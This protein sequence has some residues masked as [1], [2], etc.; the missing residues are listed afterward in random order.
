MR[1]AIRHRSSRP[2]FLYW[3]LV[4]FAALLI[5][6]APIVLAQSSPNAASADQSEIPANNGTNAAAQDQLEQAADFQAPGSLWH[7]GGFV[8]LGLLY[9][10]NDPENHLFR[11]SGTTFRVNELDLNMAAI[12]LKKSVTESSRWGTELTAQ[13]GRDSEQFGFSVTAPNLAGAQGLRH[14]GSTNVSYLAPLGKGLTLQGGIFSSFIGYDSLYAKDNFSYT[15]PWGADFTPY[16]M[17]GLNAQYPLTKRLTGTVFLI[18]GYWHLAHANDV[19]ST[20]M[21]LA[22]AP[23]DH[24]TV[25]Q[26]I[27]YGPHQANTALKFWRFLSD[28]IAEWKH[29][30]LTTAFEYFVGT[31]KVALPE[32]ART[33]WMSAQL[34]VHYAFTPTISFTVRPEVYWDR[35]GRTTGFSQTVKANTTTFEYRVPYR[36]LTAIL[37]LEHRIDD[38]RG[39]GGG[40]FTDG[41][42]PGIMPFTPTQNLG[43]VGIILTFDSTLH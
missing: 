26:T 25:K 32:G 36:D 40:F 10:P 21:Q 34:P 29:Q 41:Q 27:L 16:L 23:S 19:P 24:L 6:A 8:D 30:R 20:G 12:Y 18:S 39:P 28:S 7:Y 22:F 4:F 31:E 38:S 2:A 33:L 1:P 14:L 37:R 43:I 42:Q 9:D 17:M 15:R 3:L 35:D 11:S 5:A 13:A